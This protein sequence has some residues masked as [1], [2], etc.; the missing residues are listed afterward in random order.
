[1]LPS[2]ISALLGSIP[3]IEAAVKL[4]PEPDSP[5]RATFVLCGIEKVTP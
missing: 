1:M 5:T 2:I 3:I 4:F